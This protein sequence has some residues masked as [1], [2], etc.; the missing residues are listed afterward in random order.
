MDTMASSMHLALTALVS[1]SSLS[2][3]LP[4]LLHGIT[5]MLTETLFLVLLVVVGVARFTPA[6]HK[7]VVMNF[8]RRVLRRPRSSGF[9]LEYV[10]DSCEAT[11]TP[12]GP[13]VFRYIAFIAGAYKKPHRVVTTEMYSRAAGQAVEHTYIIFPTPTGEGEIVPGVFLSYSTS[14][15]KKAI[16]TN[17]SDREEKSTPTQETVLR[18]TT[19]LRFESQAVK[20]AFENCALKWATN[21]RDLVRIQN[22]T[23]KTN[24]PFE[25]NKTFDSLFFEEKETLL[26]L[27][28]RFSTKATEYARLGIPHTL[29][30]LLHG[31]PGTGKTSVIKAIAKRL[32]RSVLAIHNVENVDVLRHIVRVH[33]PSQYIYV[34]EEIDCGPL[35]HVVRPRSQQ[36]EEAHHACHTAKQADDPTTTALLALAAASIKKQPEEPKKEEKSKLT[37][38]DMLDFLDGLG[39]MPRRVVIFTTNYRD[40]VDPA[41]LRPGR[42]DLTIEMKRMRAVDVEDMYRLWFGR[43][44]PAHVKASVPNRTMTQAEVGQLFSCGDADQVDAAFLKGLR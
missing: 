26:K 11:R 30:L 12:S 21:K 15:Y 34:F 18:I 20:E 16:V 19:K 25:T 39:E 32:D 8:I 7:E 27:V 22:Q 35:A 37:L 42:I 6:H 36:E 9:E 13:A 2:G 41:L 5:P 1:S 24:T 17:D 23:S 14:E 33:P 38:A 4:L 43:D 44:V 40:R 28:A 29:G 31:D 3:A 10:T